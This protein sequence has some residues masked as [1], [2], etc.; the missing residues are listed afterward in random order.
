VLRDMAGMN[1]PMELGQIASL[2]SMG[3]S[4]MPEGLMTGLTDT[5]LRDLFAYLRIT[6]PLVGKEEGVAQRSS[7]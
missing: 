6:Q 4:L 3:R 7:P 2:K 5:E 1:I